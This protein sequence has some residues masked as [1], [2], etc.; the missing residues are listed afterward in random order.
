MLERRADALRVLS[1]QERITGLGRGVDRTGELAKEAMDRA[2][3]AFDEAVREAR[4]SG[5]QRIA[6]VGTSAL[7]DAGNRSVFIDRAFERTGI[8]VEVI[9]GTREAA[10][11]FRGATPGIE[12][13]GPLTVIDIGGGSTEIVRGEGSYMHSGESLDVGSVRLFERHLRT[14]PPTSTEIDA[15]RR[16]ID[17]ALDGRNLEPPILAL[18]GTACTLATVIRAKRPVARD[19]GVHGVRLSTNALSRITMEL[20]RMNS[21]ERRGMPGMIPG[22]ADVIVAGAMLLL[23]IL[24]R[25]GAEEVIISEGGVRFGLAQSMLEAA[26]ASAC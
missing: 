3:E 8:H 6:A 4:S 9:S 14:E 22:R 1:D 16:D 10:L 25:S 5:V 11:M 21:E 15:L 23:R 17:R 19:S 13:K 7:R 26:I 2:I 24:E 20:T 18:A 12:H